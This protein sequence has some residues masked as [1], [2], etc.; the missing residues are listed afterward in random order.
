MSK[1]GSHV[2]TDIR[3]GQSDILS[4]G[5]PDGYAISSTH[6]VPHLRCRCS[7][8][9]A[10]AAAYASSNSFTDHISHIQCRVAYSSADDIADSCALICSY[11]FSQ[12][13]A[14]S[15]DSSP[16]MRPDQCTVEGSD[17]RADV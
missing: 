10:L 11:R 17:S 6:V 12:L 2:I 1:C 15:S 13:L 16:Y 5:S 3:S 9:L 4:F 7:N 8:T 14:G